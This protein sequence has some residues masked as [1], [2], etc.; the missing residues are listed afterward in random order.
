MKMNVFALKTAVNKGLNVQD[1]TCGEA[2]P[3]KSS[4]FLGELCIS[5]SQQPIIIQPSFQHHSTTHTRGT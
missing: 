5:R 1:E 3:D 2:S 4:L